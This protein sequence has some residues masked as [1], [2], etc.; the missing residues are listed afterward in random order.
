MKRTIIAMTITLGL[1]CSSGTSLAQDQ[2]QAANLQNVTVTA[3]PGQYETYVVDLN[4]DYGLEVRVG[5][6]HSQYMQAQRATDRSEALRKQGMAQSP[7][8]AV[9][10]DNSSGPGLARQVQ[11]VDGAQN[12]LAIVNVYCHHVARSDGKR[13]QVVSE[14]VSTNAYSQRLAS[15]EVRPVLLAQ[16]RQ[17]RP[18]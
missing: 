15:R 2:S 5:S 12:T 16:I 13:C 17:G 3:P 11:L 9:A 1:A 8:V 14:P 10:I 18:H 7:F 6:T 4:P